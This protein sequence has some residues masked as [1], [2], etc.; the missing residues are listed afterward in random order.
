MRRVVHALTDTRMAGAGKVLLSLLS[1][2]DRNRFHHTVL[3]PEGSVLTESVRSLGFDVFEVPGMADR[4]FSLKSYFEISRLLKNLRPDVFSAN[5]CLSGRLAAARRRVPLRLSTRHCVFD[6]PAFTRFALLKKL[7]G[8]LQ[9]RLTHR[10]IAVSESSKRD[11]IREGIPEDRITVVPNG[12]L[13]MEEPSAEEVRSLRDSLSLP[14]DAF[15]VGMM[16]RL[17][18]SKGHEEAVLALSPLLESHPDLWL[19]CPGTGS[20]ESALKNLA[21]RV[22]RGRILFPGY[23]DRPSVWYRLFDLYLNNSVSTESSPLAVMEAGSFGLPLLVSDFGGNPETVSD[24]ENGLVFPVRNADALRAAVLSVKTDE[25]FRKKL[26]EG[27]KAS[28]AGRQR[29]DG[30]IRKTE[31]I[32]DLPLGK[33][34]EVKS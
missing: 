3:L 34:G 14:D 22:G 18:S 25:I 33:G 28:F 4:S 5:A 30:M 7:N 27:A 6:P 8:F 31:E 24:G 11:M 23:T 19:I 20:L 21:E 17:E 16:A 2:S 10:F 15:V 13:P 12:I 9:S 26:S 1:E 29:L 32:W